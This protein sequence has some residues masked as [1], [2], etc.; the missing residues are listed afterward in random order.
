MN[1]LYVS[2]TNLKRIVLIFTSVV[3]LASCNGNVVF[4][5]NIKLP[6]NRW[7]AGNI[8]HFT[9]TIPDSSQAMNMYI[10]LRNA[11]GYQFSN[12]FLFL[13]TTTPSGLRARDTVEL[14]LADASGRWLGDGSGDIWDNRIL[15]RKN[16]RF[17]QSGVY[18]FD[19]Q[20]AMRIDPLP[21]IMDAGI[22]LEKVSP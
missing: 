19:L 22:R 5:E 20:Q 9:V 10:N 7:A 2:M 6:E 11:E 21:Q 16:F 13:T 1:F 8:L 15:F 12:I 17:P 4:D 3:V 14:T 18:T